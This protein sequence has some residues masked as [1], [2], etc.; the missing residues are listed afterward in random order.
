[1]PVFEFRLESVLRHR[2]AME[3]KAQRE[4]SS[5]KE[6]LEEERRRLR[7]CERRRRDYR[8]EMLRK[9]AAGTVAYEFLLHRRYGERLSTELRERYVKTTSIEKAYHQ[10]L[11]ELVQILRKREALEKLKEKQ[12]MEYQQAEKKREDK[13]VDEFVIRKFGQGE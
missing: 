13:L 5:L 11:V 10:K 6:V 9:E 12:R 4:L 3:D 7:F 1:M 2:R 8:G